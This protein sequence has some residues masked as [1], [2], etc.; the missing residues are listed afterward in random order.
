LLPK[1]RTRIKTTITTPPM[2]Q[3][4]ED[5]VPPPERREQHRIAPRVHKAGRTPAVPGGGPQWDDE[6]WLF[7]ARRK[8]S[9]R[10]GKNV[11]GRPVAP[12][13]LRRAKAI[14]DAYQVVV[15]IE[16]GE[17][18][19]R[20]LEYPEAIGVGPSAAAAAVEETRAA[21]VAGVAVMLERGQY[22]PPPASE[23]A[24]T[25][26]VNIRFSAEELAL[27]TAARQQGFRGV[28]DYVRAAA[29]SG[30]RGN[31]ARLG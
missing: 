26:Q 2:I 7:T 9:A 4:M 21:M 31:T 14:I 19:G 22:P 6:I 28:S 29:L 25:E 12:A 27:E 17:Y 23:G 16:D 24:R 3:S 1:M 10:A 30:S 20:G 8:R 5:T 18:V 13:V 15:R 11:I